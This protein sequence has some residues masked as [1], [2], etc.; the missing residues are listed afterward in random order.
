MHYHISKSL[1]VVVDDDGMTYPIKHFL[2]FK[3][4]TVLIPLSKNGTNTTS[5]H[6][7]KTSFSQKSPIGKS[8]LC[9][10]DRR[11]RIT[12]LALKHICL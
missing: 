2:F 11:N 9:L 8:V 6:P 12:L 4:A 10:E 5:S 1:V 3:A 7:A